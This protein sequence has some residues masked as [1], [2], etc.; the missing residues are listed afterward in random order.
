MQGRPALCSS[1]DPL[2]PISST[3]QTR[4][5]LTNNVLDEETKQMLSYRQLLQHPKYKDDWAISSANEFGRLAQGLK[6]RVKGT[7][8]IFFIPKSQVPADRL[9][10]V[11]Y[12]KFVCKVRPEK[13][14]PNRTRL[15]VGGNRVNYPFEVGTPTA[16]M[17]LAKILFNSVVSTENA[18]FMTIDISNFYLNMPMK[19]Y[20][21]VRLNIK[22]IPGEVIEEY[23][24]RDIA[25]PDGWVYTEIRQGMYG[26]PQA[27]LI[28]QELIKKRLGEH[29]YYQD[30]YVHG[31]WHHK[32]RPGSR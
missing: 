10:D 13:K 28:A 30:Q 14:E 12:G 19:R 15:T 6:G 31:L 25:T 1:R 9:K 2:T 18:R 4:T 16:D 7:N 32:W 27:G 8:T 22:D 11:T 23:K 29:G 24:L 21:Y 20:E 5:E 26:L 3:T 17:L